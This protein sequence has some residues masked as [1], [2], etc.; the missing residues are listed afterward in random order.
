MRRKASPVQRPSRFLPPAAFSSAR[1]QMAG[2]RLTKK[3]LPPPPPRLPPAHLA[4]LIA[5]SS[6]PRESH[7]VFNHTCQINGGAYEPSRF[8][9]TCLVTPGARMC[10]QVKMGGRRLTHS[11]SPS[12][13]DHSL[14]SEK[15]SATGFSL[16]E[17]TTPHSNTHAK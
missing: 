16:R 12:P 2:S 3:S 6:S 15:I 9:Q 1:V 8:R 11:T 17:L 13:P 4:C 14:V 10:A 7:G 5:H